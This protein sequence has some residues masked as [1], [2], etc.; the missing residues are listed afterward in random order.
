MRK[1]MVV[2]AWAQRLSEETITKRKRE[3]GSF[4]IDKRFAS[5]DVLLAGA[6]T[7]GEFF[8]RNFMQN[9]TWA[10]WS[11]GLQLEENLST[12]VAD[13]FKREHLDRCTN[14][15]DC[16]VTIQLGL[17]DESFPSS[18]EK[19][20]KAWVAHVSK[21]LMTFASEMNTLTHDVFTESWI[22][23]NP[24]FN[25]N[26]IQKTFK[27]A[28]L[29]KR[30]SK[31]A[32]EMD[33]GPSGW[34]KWW[35]KADKEAAKLFQLNLKDVWVSVEFAVRVVRKHKEERAKIG[36]MIPQ[37]VPETELMAGMKQLLFEVYEATEDRL[38][39]KLEFKRKL[40]DV[41]E[42]GEDT[43]ENRRCAAASLLCQAATG[44][45]ARDIVA[46]NQIDPV[47]F[48][49]A[50]EQL[51][52][53]PA[54]IRAAFS[55]FTDE[56]ITV[57]SLSKTGDLT[58]KMMVDYVKMH[59]LTK[60]ESEEVEDGLDAEQGHFK[61][62]EI[63]FGAV[64]GMVSHQL[65]NVITKPLIY[66]FFDL[67]EYYRLESPEYLSEMYV[68][69]FEWM[70][71]TDIFF[72][73][74]GAVRRRF[75]RASDPFMKNLVADVAENPH[76]PGQ[77]SVVGEAKDGVYV[78]ELVRKWIPIMNEHMR[79]V[80]PFFN[81]G[82]VNANGSHNMRRIYVAYGYELYARNTMKEVGWASRVLAH[83]S[84]STSLVYTNLKIVLGVP[85]KEDKE[86]LKALHA[87]ID[88]IA[89][90]YRTL[91]TTWQP[92]VDEI[93][94]LM[95]EFRA[96]VDS[97]KKKRKKEEEEG[98]GGEEDEEG[99]V[100]LKTR[101]GE[102]VWVP[103]LP[104]LKRAIK[105]HK[106][107][108][109]PEKDWI[110]EGSDLDLPLRAERLEQAAQSLFDHDVAITG[111]TL[112]LVGIPAAQLKDAVRTEAVQTLIRRQSE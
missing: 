12:Y 104:R 28:L 62:G 21:T 46:V 77:L 18:G 61:R 24:N 19:E 101:E 8:S 2:E 80:F 22:L 99:K 74:F 45:R 37:R 10:S 59:N 98:E 4:K 63:D 87:K 44:G 102:D 66:A 35:E 105:K 15:F 103:R 79:R 25:K 106:G 55:G 23:Q 109:L 13:D 58:L 39:G 34:F 56:L 97:P 71:F 70:K 14:F 43:K 65:A 76:M 84:V 60:K 26:L 90:E 72:D 38:T 27:D 111:A 112:R 110:V 17:I 96:L 52:D 49:L 47:N 94:A 54:E 85:G 75:L 50:E 83:E 48:K 86:G 53:S 73:L 69:W 68:D 67:R 40:G 91:R 1:E 32:K 88:A 57:R 5:W 92:D 82:K 30:H 107:A 93:R 81:K 29:G 9:V 89:A 41:G 7:K 16:L 6:K 95:A 100:K 36:L 64:E 11:A 3:D 78:T 108:A 51:G 33:E 20:R 31:A 42:F